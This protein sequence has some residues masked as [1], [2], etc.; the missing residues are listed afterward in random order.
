MPHK[1]P[2]NTL[3]TSHI[4]SSL[5]LSTALE[6]LFLYVSASGISGDLVSGYYPLFFS[7]LSIPLP[8]KG[9]QMPL[10]LLLSVSC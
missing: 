6:W 4:I 2:L 9:D 8:V 7:P 10:L 3:K 1:H 5:L